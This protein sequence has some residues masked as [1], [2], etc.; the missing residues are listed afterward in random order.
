MATYVWKTWTGAKGGPVDAE[1]VTFEYGHVA[2]WGE[3]PP[4]IRDGSA[5][6]YPLVLAVPNTD[7]RDLRPVEDET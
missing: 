7:V 2:F 1:F 4:G 6:R 5:R 3:L